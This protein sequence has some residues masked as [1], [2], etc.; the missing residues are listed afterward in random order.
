MRAGVAPS[1]GWACGKISEGID[2]DHTGTGRQV[3][4]L[5]LPTDS[6]GREIMGK[7]TKMSSNQ[8]TKPEQLRKVIY[9][10]SA[11]CGEMPGSA[12]QCGASS[13]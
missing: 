4:R 2:F 1:W 9:Y 12:S 8:S 13:L 3:N 5:M 11:A 10:S 7:R 6:E